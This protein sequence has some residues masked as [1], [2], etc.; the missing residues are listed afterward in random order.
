MIFE[1]V[2]DMTQELKDVKPV[3]KEEFGRP[4]KKPRHKPVNAGVQQGVHALKR[5]LENIMWG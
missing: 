4:R 3:Q 1:T 2:L 5:S